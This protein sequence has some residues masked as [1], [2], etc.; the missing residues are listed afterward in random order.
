MKHR[1]VSVMAMLRQC[2]KNKI[3][4]LMPSCFL[5]NISG[6]FPRFLKLGYIIL[7]K[8]SYPDVRA[9]EGDAAGII[10]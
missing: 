6:R 7:E 2:A 1:I 10:V 5:R 4:P 3:G 8:A 9:V